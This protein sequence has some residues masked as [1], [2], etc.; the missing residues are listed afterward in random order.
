VLSYIEFD[1]QF[2][3]YLRALFP[4]CRDVQRKIDLLAS[5]SSNSNTS[6]RPGADSIGVSSIA[7]SVTTPP[8]SR[9]VEE[10]NSSTDFDEPS[11]LSLEEAPPKI[12]GEV[13]VDDSHNNDRTQIIQEVK[14]AIFLDAVKASPE[15]GCF[16][17][18]RMLWLVA[19]A[20]IAAAVLIGGVCGLASAHRLPKKKKKWKLLPVLGWPSSRMI[21]IHPKPNAHVSF[22]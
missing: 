4:K 3:L 16:I 21:A 10:G 22:D 18:K 12:T 13:V 8:V 5:R 19:L 20:V 7:S 2:T 6:R 11:S 9:G 1:L 17:R 15:T 14:E